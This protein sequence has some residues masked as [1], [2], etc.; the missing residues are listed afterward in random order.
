MEWPV[1]LPVR[2]HQ[3]FLVATGY[4]DLGNLDPLSRARF[5]KGCEVYFNPEIAGGT[6]LSDVFGIAAFPNGDI[7]RVGAVQPTPYVARL[8]I[9]QTFGFGGEQEKVQSGP[10]QLAECKDYSRLTVAAGKVAATDWFDNNAYSH[11][12]RSQFMN[13]CLMYNGAWDYP[14]DVRGY[15]Y[16][17]VVELNQKDWALRYGIFAEPEVANGDRARPQDRRGARAGGRAGK[18]VQA[19]QS[20]RQNPLDGLLE[21]RPHGRLQRGHRDSA[22][23]SRRDR[24]GQ[25]RLDQVRL[26]HQRGA[27]N[28]RQAGRFPAAG[29]ER[30][31]HRDLGLHGMRPDGGLRL[32]SQGR[33]WRRDGDEIGSGFVINGLSGPHRAYLAPAAWASSWATGS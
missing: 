33:P 8:W 6:G 26:R 3:Q 14:A 15:T 30:R 1:S 4:G 10:N 9:Q 7:T 13:W 5:W 17:V 12:P 23:R 2:R 31:P 29:L 32:H 19:V 22:R 20:S 16:G 25:L 11:D 28:H 27:G 21:P 18:P 24:N